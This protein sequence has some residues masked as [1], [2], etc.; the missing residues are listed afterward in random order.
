M[1][2]Q[3]ATIEQ[4]VSWLTEHQREHCA[5]AAALSTF[6]GMISD[7]I[8]LPQSAAEHADPAQLV[9]AMTAWADALLN[10]AYFLPGEFA[11]EALWSY[12]AHD[13]VAQAK[14]GGHAQYFANRGGD[15]IALRCCGSGLKSMLA[16]PH[17]ELFNTLVR[18]QRSKPRVARRLAAQ[19]G[20]RSVSAAVRE[21]DRRLAELE[22]REPLMPRHKAW[23][24]S[25]RKIRIVPDAEMNQQ[26]NRVAASNALFTQRRVEAERARAESMRSDPAHRAVKELCDMAGLQFAGLRARGHAPMRTLWPEGPDSRG[27]VFRVET[28]RGA[29]FALIYTEGRVFKR[30]LAVLIEQGGALPL[31][32]L[33]LSSEDYRAI[34][35][36][37]AS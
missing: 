16:D 5:G 37:T 21:L 7:E 10:Q 9:L 12:Y 4:P 25:L 13:Y 3:P 36:A 24:K 26:L 15:E 18:L 31:G 32:S 11:Q 27:Y 28:N 17:L 34:L 33:T 20:Q 30:R 23:L 14:T 1:T 2:E 22:Q 19:L 6:Q 35:P 8:F 29:R